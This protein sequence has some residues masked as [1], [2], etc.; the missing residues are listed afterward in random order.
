M[1]DEV[2]AKFVITIQEEE[3]DIHSKDHLKAIIQNTSKNNNDKF[4]DKKYKDEL[5][6]IYLSGAI[7]HRQDMIARQVYT[8]HDFAEHLAT[9]LQKRLENFGR[10]VNQIWV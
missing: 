7:I 1:I 4:W 8:I 3:Y 5:D 9:I 10:V 2:R 6:L